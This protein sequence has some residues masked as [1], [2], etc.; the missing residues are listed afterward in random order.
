MKV[1]TIYDGTLQSKT[2]LHYGIKKVRE[3]GGDLVVLHVFP[4]SMFIDYDAGPK[5]EELARMEWAQH[6]REAEAIIRETGS[7]MQIRLVSEDGDPEQEVQRYAAS[8][9]PD[10]VLATPRYKAITKNGPGNV[11]IMPG[12]ILVPIDNSDAVMD[13]VDTI[14]EE[15]RDTGS[16]VLLLGIIPIHLY[17]REE[18]KELDEVKKS[19]LATMRKIKKSLAGKG[20][21]A[22]E[23]IRS[24][25]PDE[26][27]LKAAGEF[28]VSLII[29]PSGGKTPSELTKAAAVLLEEPERVKRPVCLLQAAGGRGC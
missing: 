7:G 19:T 3:K 6:A 20:I 24:G 11:Y 10:L 8:E 14:I 16:T 1:L 21:E 28:S 26:E 15:A 29:L 25:Y 22:S 18:Q 23:A 12:T 9:H 17:S 27:I 4:S 2:A 13:G 5:A